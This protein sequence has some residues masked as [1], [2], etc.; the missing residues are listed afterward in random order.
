M[1]I[2]TSK[3]SIVDTETGQNITNGERDG[4]KA[5]LLSSHG[6]EIELLN[7]RSSSDSTNIINKIYNQVREALSEVDGGLDEFEFGSHP[8]RY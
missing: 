3:A 7:L 5:L 4:S 6:K 8:P 1:W 2:Q